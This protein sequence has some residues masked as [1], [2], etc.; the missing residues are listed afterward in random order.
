MKKEDFD[1]KKYGKILISYVPNAHK[2]LYTTP[3]YESEIRTV[4]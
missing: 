4:N 1:S 3:K 2:N